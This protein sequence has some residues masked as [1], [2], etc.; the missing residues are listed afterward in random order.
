M[1]PI[2]VAP[3]SSAHG[4]HAAR[5]KPGSENAQ[6]PGAFFA[7]LAGLGAHALAGDEDAPLSIGALAG[8]GDA[9]DPVDAPIGLFADGSPYALTA[10]EAGNALGAVPASASLQGVAS[11]AVWAAAARGAGPQGTDEHKGVT[12]KTGAGSTVRAENALSSRMDGRSQGGA[13]LTP[14]GRSTL[15]TRM[16]GMLATESRLVLMGDDQSPLSIGALAEDGGAFDPIGTPIGLFVD[17]SPYALMMAKEAGDALGAL[18]ASASLQG[19]ANDAVS[20][21]AVSGAGP[22]GTDALGGGFIKTCAGGAAR[23]KDALSSRLDGRSQG[24]AASTPGGRSTLATR[25]DGMF[26]SEGHL[27]AGS[28]ANAGLVAQTVR[29][30]AVNAAPTVGVVGVQV[31]SLSSARRTTNLA[32]SAKAQPLAQAIDAAGKP[33]S[34]AQ[35]AGV[36]ALS[37]LKEMQA[38]L[39]SPSLQA[40]RHTSAE[41][42]RSSTNDTS[43]L[44]GLFSLPSSAGAWAGDLPGGHSQQSANERTGF[45]SAA[46]GQAWGESAVSP[47]ME[48]GAGTA[49][50]G[51]LSPEE[52]VAEQVTYW[53]S[54]NL[55]NAELTVEHAGQPVEVRVSLAGNEAHVAFRS[56]QAE[57]RELLNARLEQL[58]ELLQ[59]QGL[60]LSGATVDT[61]TSGQSGEPSGKSAPE[62]AKTAGVRPATDVLPQVPRRTLTSSAVDLYV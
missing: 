52:A 61:G 44:T 6:Q 32:L 24:A 59:G 48:L 1:D 36:G 3:S 18:P 29:M 13:A 26:A 30:D 22:Q 55:K 4:S 25:M 37:T 5:Q 33:A 45:V 62:G 16:H 17:G 12:A 50:G 2:R 34:L 7:L 56:D 14:G 35:V 57:I 60:Q 41:A 40:E 58:R 31:P 8:D 43:G 20:A 10:K 46:I 28:L 51:V 42:G 47:T 21:V 49:D 53:L 19:I 23:A 15:A 11:D 54:E 38:A 27:L 9:T 39:T